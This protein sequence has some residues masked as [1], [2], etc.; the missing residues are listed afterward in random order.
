MQAPD[1]DPS[2]RRVL[3]Y[4][5]ARGILGAQDAAWSAP[6]AEDVSASHR[7]IRVRLEGR[8][9]WFVKWADAERSHGRD[10]GSEAAV[11]RLSTVFPQLARVLP[12][13][14]LVG[15]RDD[16]LVLDALPGEPLSSVLDWEGL[17]RPGAALDLAAYGSA[18]AT[19]HAVR[20]PRF[21]AAPWLIEAL[22]PRWGDYE[23]LPRWC[24]DFLRRL[25]ASPRF[26]AGFLAARREWRPGCLVHGD[27]RWANVLLERRDD[28]RRVWIVDWELA[29]LGDPAW[30]VGCAVGDM[31]VTR[32]QGA[33]S[34]AAPWAPMRS[35][36]A[37]YRAEARLDDIRWQR[38]LARSA[39]LAAVRL[40]QSVIEQGHESHQL[41]WA[42]ES[43]LVPWALYLLREGPAVG[44][45]LAREAAAA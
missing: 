14:W 34:P 27:L 39:R 33:R 12:R 11:Y 20:P 24:A 36:L 2:A 3:Q 41:L 38:L 30:D 19:F 10:L 1:W 45:D 4:L 23:W 8:A 15:E 26:R 44:L 35:F 28:R 42:A 31:V 6:T 5:I 40:V 18:T 9:R 16:I 37:A 7:S 21:G 22:E 43:A 13:C 17:D 29:C 32:V 25:R